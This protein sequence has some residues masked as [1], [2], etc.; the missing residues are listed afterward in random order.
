MQHLLLATTN[1]AK[2]ARLRW[3]VDGLPFAVRTPREYP[4]ATPHVPED[5]TDFAT[6]AAQKA[7]GW[8]AATGG[9]LTLASDGGLAIPALGA[10]WDALRTR[11]NA[12]PEAT[13][14]ERIR[15]LLDL[16]RDLHG[17]ERRACWHEALAL[18][19]DGA[20]LQTW[21]ASGDGGLIVE[22]SLPGQIDTA[23]WTEHI[24]YYP[25]AGKLYRDLSVEEAER[26]DL[27]W[28][29]LRD[30]VR[31]YLPQVSRS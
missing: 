20:V 6:N 31:T 23:F 27:V 21:T 15:H 7:Q 2:L 4:A 9:M 12:G 25:A 19:R 28:P 30:E 16:M 1:P 22:Q 5:G 3:V 10:R 17:E 14:A 18:A 29:R 11:R 26:L 13:N 8:S 24:R